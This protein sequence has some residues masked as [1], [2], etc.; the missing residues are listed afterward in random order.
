MLKVEDRVMPDY[1]QDPER[2]LR[3]SSI[4]VPA[5][6]LKESINQINDLA[7]ANAIQ[8]VHVAYDERVDLSPLND[9]HGIKILAIESRSPVRLPRELKVHGVKALFCNC[10]IFDSSAFPDLSYLET[11]HIDLSASSFK[12]G[13]E[14]KRIC[15]IGFRCGGDLS[16][17][18]A[19]R[20]LVDLELV[21][22]RSITSLNGLQALSEL[23]RLC[24]A[25]LS[26]LQ[27]IEEIASLHKLENLVVER[28]QGISSYKA[29]AKV[30]SLKRLTI[31]ASAPIDQLD[32]RQIDLLDILAIWDTKHPDELKS[33]I[34]SAR[35][36]SAENAG[37]QMIG[38]D[39]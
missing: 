2:P 21:R 24:L 39:A 34:R 10:H 31:T 4:H 11:R 19:L 32:T 37:Q 8:A 13:S 9:L 20:K 12:E 28:L 6:S 22:A 25:Q 35:A 26:K 38:I 30:S 23:R 1:I 15:A 7:L 5:S 36:R 3:Y 18:A 16:G 33:I 14:L 17:L 27:S 29:I